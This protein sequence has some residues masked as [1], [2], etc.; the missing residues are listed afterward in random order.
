MQSPFLILVMQTVLNKTYIYINED[1]I[2][3]LTCKKIYFM[4][5]IL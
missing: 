5:F 4:Y 1:K 3:L 2:N